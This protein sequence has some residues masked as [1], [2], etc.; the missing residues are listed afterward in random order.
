MAALADGFW[1]SERNPS[2]IDSIMGACHGGQM[3]FN[4]SAQS[5]RYGSPA[6]RASVEIE[7]GQRRHFHVR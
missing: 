3:R 5:T 4:D 6:F 2:E 1:S 7:E